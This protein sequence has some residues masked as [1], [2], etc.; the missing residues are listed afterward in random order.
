MP[1]VRQIVHWIVAAILLLIS[2]LGAWLVIGPGAGGVHR[3]G[4][5]AADMAQD[6]FERRVRACLLENPEVVA[7]ALQRLELRQQAAQA[8]EAQAALKKH[9]EELL[10]DPASP[11]GGNPHG[12][13]SLVEFFDYNC[14]TAARW[15]R[16]W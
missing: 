12:D 3:S 6:E 9:A 7:E 13:V 1:E 4:A 16:A 10:R 8:S 14:P 5:L 15:R 11:V 2:A